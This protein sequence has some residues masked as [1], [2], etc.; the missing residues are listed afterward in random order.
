MASAVVDILDMDALAQSAAL[1][2]K[3]LSAADLMQATLAR[4]EAVNGTVNAVV[5]LRD[6]DDLMAEARAADA[7]PRKGWLHGIPMAIKDLANVAGL[8]T[9]GVA[10]FYRQD[11]AQTDDLMV[12]RLRAAGAIFIGK[13]NT[14][15]FGLG[16]HTFNPVHGA[17]PTPMTQAVPR[18]GRR[19]GRRRRWPRGC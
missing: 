7:A 14:P 13:T 19:A 12:S 18:V 2:S 16:S 11:V 10:A 8:P 1:D 4:I 3:Q 5:S 6:A 9:R 17:T 15:E